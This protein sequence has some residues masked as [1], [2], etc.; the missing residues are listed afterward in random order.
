MVQGTDVFVIGGGPAGLAAALAARK[1]GFKA[2]VADVAR[3]PIDKACGEGLMPDGL[4]A[5][6]D[7]G[8][9]VDASEGFP[10]RGVRF[11]QEGTAVDANFPA[12]HGM[13]LR[14][15][16]LHQKMV[17]Q[18]RDAG[19]SFLW[20][21]PVAGLCPEGVVVGGT[22]ITARWIVGADGMRSQVRKWAELDTPAH[23]GIRFAFRRHY[24]V[25]PWSEYMEIYWGRDTQ[26]YVTPVGKQEVCA[27]LISRLP[28]RRLASLGAEFPQLAERLGPAA[29]GVERGAITVVRQLDQ[30]YREQ[31]AL[32]GDASGSVDAVTGEGLSLSFHQAAAL[33]DALAAGDLRHYQKAHRRLARR[34]AMTGRLMLLLAG[35]EGLRERAMHA[36]ASD[37]GIFARL[38]AVH[39]GATSPVHLATTGVLLGWRLVTA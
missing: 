34:P 20:Q 24:H 4:A 26:A 7:L 15:S 32:I 11:L 39:V 33:A 21:T 29:G 10:F 13:G 38:L 12:R 19:V 6:R 30:V 16:V 27:V 35:H 5:L 17:E 14:R 28:G 2:I 36:L 18:A 9:A 1:K 25:R 37:A 3:P 31:V 8:V 22:V 23:K